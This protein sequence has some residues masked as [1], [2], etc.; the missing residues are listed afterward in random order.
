MAVGIRQGKSTFWILTGVLTFSVRAGLYTQNSHLYLEPHQPSVANSSADSSGPWELGSLWHSSHI[1]GK[2]VEEWMLLWVPRLVCTSLLMGG[3]ATTPTSPPGKAISCTCKAPS[4]Q[5]A[6]ARSQWPR[7]AHWWGLWH[8]PDRQEL[9]NVSCS[10]LVSSQLSTEGSKEMMFQKQLIW[11]SLL[12][13][14]VLTETSQ[15]YSS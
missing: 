5:A 7:N 12:D 1:M 2:Q 6:L 10:C 14:I 11:I 4:P 15:F 8:S 13:H 3:S 9:G